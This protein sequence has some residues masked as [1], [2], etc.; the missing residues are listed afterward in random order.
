MDDTSGSPRRK[1][2]SPSYPSIPLGLAVER[3]KVVYERER[4]HS[5]PILSLFTAWGFKGQTGPAVVNLAA[6]KKYGL[7]E[8]E[9]TGAARKAK[10]TALA[11]DIILAPGEDHPRR[12]AA[13]REAALKPTIFADLQSR[14]GNDLPSD[15]T[16]R[17][18]LVRERKFLEKAASEVIRNYRES[19]Q[20]AGLGESATVSVEPES[21]AEEGAMPVTTSPPPQVVHAPAGSI[22]SF[23]PL[24]VGSI[25]LPISQGE[26]ATLSARFPMTRAKWDQM[27]RILEVMKG[28]LVV[29]DQAPDG[30]RA[31]EEDTD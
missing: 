23:A 6:L 2:R 11:L 21:E 22:P 24:P 1:D 15:E 27:L 13:L 25:Q 20:L 28:G 17:Y 12:L 29:E 31:H 3:A 16:M 19:L 18:Y 7:L 5:A 4:R 14:Y 8:D 9:G 10:L 26:W 30:K